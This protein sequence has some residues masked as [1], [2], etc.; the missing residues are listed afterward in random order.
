MD[1]LHAGAPAM[2][3]TVLA[4]VLLFGLAA[5]GEVRA[6]TSEWSRLDPAA[7]SGDQKTQQADGLAAKEALFS[8][9]FLRLQTAFAD[10]PAEAIAACRVSAP[11]I[12]AA[13]ASERGLRIGRT[14]H[15]LRNPQNVAPDWAEVF[16]QARTAEPVWLAHEDGRLAGL[17]PIPTKAMC[18]TC[19]GSED[20]IQ[21]PIRKALDE[22][23]PQ[24]QATGFADGDLRGWFWLEIPAP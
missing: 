3:N 4:L 14:S 7:L 23:Y 19:H 1:R 5:C 2:Q 6:P 12:A 18:L 11:E 24:D 16:V 10:G 8:Q 17:L 13:V 20:S 9:L 22:L 15:R 21:A